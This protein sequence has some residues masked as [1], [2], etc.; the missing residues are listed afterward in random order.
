[1]DQWTKNNIRQCT[2]PVCKHIIVLEQ[3]LPRTRI[4]QRPLACF[5][6]LM[7]HTPDSWAIPSR[8]YETSFAS[9]DHYCIKVFFLS[10]CRTMQ[11]KNHGTTCNSRLTLHGI[12]SEIRLSRFRARQ[13][14]KT[15]KKPIPFFRMTV[16]MVLRAIPLHGKRRSCTKEKLFSWLAVLFVEL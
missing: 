7:L 11:L 5:G 2:L 10:L 14:R 13:F 4:W 12:L 3:I 8:N 1:M 6:S 9:K 16:S 15:S